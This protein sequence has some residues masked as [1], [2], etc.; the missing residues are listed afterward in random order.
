VAGSDAVLRECLGN[1]GDEL[2]QGKTAINVARALAEFL[3]KRGHVVAGHLEQPPQAG[4]LFVR[5]HIG[6][7]TVFGERQFKGVCVVDI[8]DVDGHREKLGHLRGAK[9]SR[10]CNDLEAI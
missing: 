3:R 7:Q 2:Q 5:M 6:P 1:F 9:A 4:S 8:D 10:A